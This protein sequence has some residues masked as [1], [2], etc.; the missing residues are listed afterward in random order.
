MGWLKLALSL[1][2]MMSRRNNPPGVS[3]LPTFTVALR[4]PVENEP[5]TTSTLL[6]GPKPH[7]L[8][9]SAEGQ[10]S[11]S[12]SERDGKGGEVGRWSGL[13]MTTQY[14]TS[15]AGVEDM[16]NWHG[17]GYPW[18]YVALNVKTTGNLALCDDSCKKHPQA[19]H[20]AIRLILHRFS[21]PDKFLVR[22]H[23]NHRNEI[24][25]YSGEAPVLPATPI[26]WPDAST[27]FD[28]LPMSATKANADLLRICKFH[29]LSRPCH[30]SP[31]PRAH[32]HARL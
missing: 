3:S 15:V 5:G 25:A 26:G 11:R 21:V 27:D 18:G 10:H 32:T 2:W 14:P 23:V 1:T 30:G 9:R 24:E 17:D 12:R 29:L 28:Q 20:D 7:W 22:W 19:V 16:H 13:D 31:P 4:S 6:E 8:K